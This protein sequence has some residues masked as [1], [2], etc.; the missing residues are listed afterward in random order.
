MK[1]CQNPPELAHRLKYGRDNNP[2]QSPQFVG[3]TRSSPL[4]FI[5]LTLSRLNCKL[6]TNNR[7][8]GGGW[9]GDTSR[10]YVPS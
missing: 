5:V 1:F 3:S 4:L 10:V 2:V 8:K 6:E 7:I 9:V